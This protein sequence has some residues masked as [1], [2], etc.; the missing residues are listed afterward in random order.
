MTRYVG[1]W[2]GGNSY[3]APDIE[4]AE[5]FETIE[6][7]KNAMRSRESRGYWQPQTFRNVFRPESN[8]LTPAAHSEWSGYVD[9]Y[10]VSK[11]ATEDEIRT[12]I[13]DGYGFVRLEF[14]PRGGIRRENG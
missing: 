6:E 2:H 5:Y 13:E 9:L 10:R 4:D 1:L 3:A 7:A 14:G 8:D 11:N 12:A